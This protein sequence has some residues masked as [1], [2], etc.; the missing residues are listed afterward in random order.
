MNYFF[1]ELTP[2]EQLRRRLLESSRRR[3]RLLLLLQQ[4]KQ[5]SRAYG[6]K[7]RRR[8]ELN[9]TLPVNKPGQLRRRANTKL[10]KS[11]SF[12]SFLDVALS[13]WICLA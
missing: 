1:L 13:F 5:L 6:A 8:Y 12:F 11:G 4:R 3:Q 9:G 2:F 10:N 7:A